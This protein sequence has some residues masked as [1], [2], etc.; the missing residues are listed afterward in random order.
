[1]EN[2]LESES[3]SVHLSSQYFCRKRSGRSE[4]FYTGTE[5]AC[6]YFYTGCSLRNY[7][8]RSG[9]RDCRPF[10]KRTPFG[11]GPYHVSAGIR[12]PRLCSRYRAGISPV[13]FLYSMYVA[14]FYR[15]IQTVFGN[16]EKPGQNVSRHNR[17]Y[18]ADTPVWAGIQPGN[19]TGD[20]LQ[21]Q[22]DG[23]PDEKHQYILTKIQPKV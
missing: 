19:F 6:K 18:R 3:S 8:F 17:I 20:L 11:N 15:N 23:V 10:G 9:D 2:S 4:I 5:N 12:D 21:S 16:M 13:Y 14:A 22:S 1:M 7:C